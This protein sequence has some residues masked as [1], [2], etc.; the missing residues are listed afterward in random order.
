MQ[1]GRISPILASL[2]VDIHIYENKSKPDAKDCFSLLEAVG[3]A[4]ISMEG[5][6]DEIDELDEPI[7][8]IIE[9]V[10]TAKEMQPY[11]K[12]N[13]LQ[14]LDSSYATLID[15][16]SK[17]TSSILPKLSS[18]LEE[19][20]ALVNIEKNLE[21]AGRASDDGLVCFKIIKQKVDVS[22]PPRMISSC[23]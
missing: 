2:Y 14:K 5:G 12:G 10:F 20:S 15:W 19:Y 17:L 6:L 4:M 13:D 23:R 11:I 7:Q 18:A 3:E 9:I 1:Q 16:C 8:K 21:S 22:A